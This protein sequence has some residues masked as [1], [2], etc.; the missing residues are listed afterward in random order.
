[1]NV[2]A[3]M[4]IALG[5]IAPVILMA[6]VGFLLGRL[7]V[8]EPEPVARIYMTV[9]APALAFKALLAQDLSGDDL[10]RVLLFCFIS[11]GV[12]M[13]LAHAGSRALRHDR[14]MRGAFVNSIILYNSANYGFPVQELA[15]PGLGPVIQPIVLMTQN[16]VAFTLGPFNAASNSPSLWATAKR[17]ATM[18]LTWALVLGAVLHLA[19]L[20]W[21]GLRRD[22]PI[23]WTPLNYFQ[24]ALVPVALLSLGVQLSRVRIRGKILNITVG[25]VLR[26]LVAPLVGLAVGLALG[27]RAELLA[28]LVV[29]ISFPSAVFTSVLA[30]EFKNHEE[31][32]AAVVFVS[33]VISIVT[34]TLVIYL[35]RV[36][37]VG[38]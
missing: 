17:L 8:V 24:G 5:V 27:I 7:R 30:T 6:A 10:G 14:G 22:V 26:L 19:G 1:M 9:F 15:F 16:L 21:D 37:L 11:V 34:V 25:T 2:D 36:Y 18:P 20:T 3:L 28:V 12:L 35:T 23:L 13:L 38:G 32:A 4:E 33:T 31:Y 29:S